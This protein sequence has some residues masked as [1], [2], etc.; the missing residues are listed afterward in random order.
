M[1]FSHSRCTESHDYFSHLITLQ[2]AQQW[3]GYYLSPLLLGMMCKMHTRTPSS[4]REKNLNIPCIRTPPQLQQCFTTSMG[5]NTTLLANVAKAPA[6]YGMH[7][8]VMLC[9]VTLKL[10]IHH[11][12]H[13]TKC[14]AC[15]GPLLAPNPCLLSLCT[16]PLTPTSGFFSVSLKDREETHHHVFHQVLQPFLNH[17]PASLPW[18]QICNRK[19]FVVILRYRTQ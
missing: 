9:A 3:R 7:Q 16:S 1:R 17:L 11:L 12:I 13:S 19:S 14:R 5:T 4:M 6:I 10:L 2:S 15:T 8:Q 18:D